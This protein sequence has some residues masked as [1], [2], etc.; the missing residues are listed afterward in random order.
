MTAGGAITRAA[1]WRYPRLGNCARVLVGRI[2]FWKDVAV[3]WAGPRAAPCIAMLE[4]H[5]PNVAKAGATDV[6]WRPSL[7]ALAPPASAAEGFASYLDPSL[8]VLVDV[9]VFPRPGE[10]PARIEEARLRAEPVRAWN[11]SEKVVKLR[12]RKT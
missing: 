3:G 10:R 2:A 6:V 8:R 7:S 4:A 12:S 1:A 11:R 9:L 5:T